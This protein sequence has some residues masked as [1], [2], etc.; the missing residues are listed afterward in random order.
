MRNPYLWALVA[1]VALSLV[2]FLWIGWEP[3]VGRPPVI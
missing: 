3:L 2:C 1:L